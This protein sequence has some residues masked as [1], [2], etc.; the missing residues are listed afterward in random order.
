MDLSASWSSFLYCQ[1]L[2]WKPL[3][4]SLHP[5]AWP[6]NCND[7]FNCTSIPFMEE[8]LCDTACITEGLHR[9]WAVRGASKKCHFAQECRSHPVPADI[10]GDVKDRC[11][12]RCLPLANVRQAAPEITAC[13]MHEL[14]LKGQ[15]TTVSFL[16]VMIINVIV[17]YMTTLHYQ[18]RG[19]NKEAWLQVNEPALPAF[20]DCTERAFR[21][22][23]RND[24]LWRAGLISDRTMTS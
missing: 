14:Q 15:V 18:L 17:S 6:Y 4:V 8:A 16:I 10:E 19:R 23:K 2:E 7:V 5:G 20:L 13:D 1:E 3:I 21:V 22:P 11:I 24:F 9:F 12:W